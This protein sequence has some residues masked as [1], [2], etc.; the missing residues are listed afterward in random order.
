MPCACQRQEPAPN[1]VVV[2]QVTM[3]ERHDVFRQVTLPATVEAFE[4]ATLYAK[5]AGYLKWIRVD[6]GDR[7]RKGEVIAEIDVPEMSPELAGSEAEIERAKANIGN[8]QAE[9][10]RAKAELQLKRITYDRV[11]SIRDAEPDVMPQQQVDET[12]AQFEVAR[13]NGERSRKQGTGCTGRGV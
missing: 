7:V 6:I 8:V 11:K 9:L 10:E 13:A 12:R 5:V 1:E 2:V 4:Q 3:P